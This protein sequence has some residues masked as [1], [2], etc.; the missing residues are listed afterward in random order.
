M[1]KSLFTSK[2]DE[3]KIGRIFDIS[4]GI[5]YREMNWKQKV[6]GNEKFIAGSSIYNWR[7]VC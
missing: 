2:C 7:D 3:K 1:A 5:W 4:L 6:E